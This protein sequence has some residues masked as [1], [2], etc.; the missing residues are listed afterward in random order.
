MASPP[1]SPTDDI[2]CRC[3]GAP[4]SWQDQ[5]KRNLSY[6]DSIQLH[7]RTYLSS[8][9]TWPLGYILN[10]PYSPLHLELQ[11]SPNKKY[12]PWRDAFEDL[13][14]VQ[15]GGPLI[16]QAS[17]KQEG[18]TM[19]HLHREHSNRDVQ[20]INK[21][22]HRCG[23]WLRISEKMAELSAARAI[24]ADAKFHSVAREEAIP[25]F[26]QMLREQ[27]A[28][29]NHLVENM[30]R[31]DALEVLPPASMG[32]LRGQWIASL[33]TSGAMK[34]WTS[35]LADSADGEYYC[36]S[37]AQPSQLESPEPEALCMTETELRR[38]FTEGMP[39]VPGRP[40]WI[41]LSAPY[42]GV[43]RA[44]EE[45]RLAEEATIGKNNDSED[46]VRALGE[47]YLPW[48]KQRRRR[49][50]EEEAPFVLRQFVSA[51]REEKGAGGEVSVKLE[52]QF[53]DGRSERKE[54]VGDKGRVLE[55]VDRCYASMGRKRAEIA[56]EALDREVLA[57]VD[58][59]EDL[60]PQNEE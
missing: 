58:I 14:S 59:L 7:M 9:R 40:S 41:T 20:K 17:R 19:R 11:P 5:S 36:F 35:S 57:F 49:G 30:R 2:L 28:H 60:E 56:E 12:F 24:L 10:S 4:S 18:E 43:W 52:T 42:P 31:M 48:R 16:S 37:K 25:R 21:N 53:E 15:S 32:M 3:C 47:K 1:A 54:I 27:W 26:Q 8:A 38:C 55:E 13:L 34:G 46:R 29:G 45:A 39:L 44:S 22:L 33:I 6:I 51:E 23:L 50:L